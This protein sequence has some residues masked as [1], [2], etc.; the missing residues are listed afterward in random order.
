MVRGCFGSFETWRAVSSVRS[1][2]PVILLRMRACWSI[3]EEFPRSLHVAGP[4]DNF[5]I[6]PNVSL[7]PTT[8]HLGW[9]EGCF[10]FFETSHSA[11]PAKNNRSPRL[12]SVLCIIVGNFF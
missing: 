2:A 10:G 4:G 5:T 11:V 12:C 6:G 7:G 1:L 3:S 8:R 9:V